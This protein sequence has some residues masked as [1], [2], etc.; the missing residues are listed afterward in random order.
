MDDKTSRSPA[1]RATALRKSFV[2]DDETVEAVRG[3]DLEVD[4]GEIFGL[5]GPNGAGKT[6]S[7]RMLTTLLAIDDGSA[8]VA[9]VD[10]AADPAEVRRRIGCVGQ[11]GGADL[12]A[13]GRENLLLQAR[14]F[15][16][17]PSQAQRRSEELIEQL[18]LGEFVNRKA[19]T[20]SGGQRRRLEVALG[21]VN[22]PQVLFLDEPTTGLD[23]QNRA[24]LWDQVRALRAAGTAVVLTTHYLEEADALAD[25][26]AI[27]D[28]GA[29]VTEGPPSELKRA[30]AGEAIIIRPKLEGDRLVEAFE[31]LA[32]EPLVREARR[33]GEALRLYVADAATALPRLLEL[34]RSRSVPL[35]GITMSEASLDDVFLR[36]TGRSLRDTGRTHREAVAG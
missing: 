4:A 14:L 32:A 24:N 35:Q 15:G 34:L 25:R 27:I 23:P 12:P 22:R 11:G 16:M 2:V 5:L 31:W 17:S 20:Y 26:V 7:M 1:L 10:V 36:E 13:T 19:R 21:V 3:I 18:Q 9:G 8:E 29:V 30:V 28:R 6:T 33:E